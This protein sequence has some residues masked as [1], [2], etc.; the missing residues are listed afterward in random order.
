[1]INK[2]FFLS[3]DTNLLFKRM[4]GVKIVL[5]IFII[6]TISNYGPTHLN[7]SCLRFYLKSK[8][9]NGDLL[10]FISKE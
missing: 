1:M 8:A 5:V 2:N 6:N 3:E 4:D 9:I 7:V 10:K